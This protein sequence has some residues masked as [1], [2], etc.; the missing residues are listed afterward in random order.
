MLPATHDSALLVLVVSLVCLG[1]WINTFKA[2]GRTWRFELFSLDFA[3]GAMV[4]A[5]V[6]AF[7]LGTMGSDLGFADRTLVAGHTASALGVV[8]GVV[9]NLGNMLLLA[10]VSLLG[11]STAFPFVVGVA[12]IV[13]SWFQFREG[14]ALY[15]SGGILLM[16][17]AVFFETRSARLRESQV[18]TK[19]DTALTGAGQN[20]RPAAATAQKA[21]VSA[22]AGHPVKKKPPVKRKR[23]KAVRGIGVAIIAGAVLAGVV[24]TLDS[25]LPGDLGLGP[26]SGMVLFGIGVLAS[27]I[28]YDFFFLNVSIDGVPLTFASYFRGKVGQHIVGLL[29]GAICMGGLLTAAMVI[30]SPVAADVKPM[31]RLVLPLLSVLLAFLFGISIWKELSV[32]TG[33]RVANLAGMLLFLCSL[34]LFAYGFTL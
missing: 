13:S 8:A 2:V 6:L 12:L 16:L 15:L 5:L 11:A 31:V 25:C 28:F 24:P 14:N 29:G 33:S 21:S 17:I 1:S 7:T 10:A 26:Y 27:T 20:P 4:T 22:S 18:E 3:L 32:P 9:F 23:V 34:G 30:W 19:K